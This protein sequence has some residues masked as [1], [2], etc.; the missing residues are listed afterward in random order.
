MDEDLEWVLEKL[1]YTRGFRLFLAP[2]NPYKMCMMASTPTNYAEKSWNIKREYLPSGL[3]NINL[4]NPMTFPPAMKDL[5]P[6]QPKGFF[7]H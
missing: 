4:K 6:A 7:K 5:G 3:K 2:L 1:D